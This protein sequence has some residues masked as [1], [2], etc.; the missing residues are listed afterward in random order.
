MGENVKCTKCEEVYRA[1]RNGE[2]EHFIMP[3]NQ[4]RLSTPLI[5]FRVLVPPP[6]VQAGGF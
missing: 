2:G 1:P 4:K 5:F 6:R 3:R